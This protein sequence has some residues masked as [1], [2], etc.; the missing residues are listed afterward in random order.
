LKSQKPPTF[1]LVALNGHFR[2]CPNWPDVVC[3]FQCWFLTNQFQ[4]FSL[5]VFL[6]IKNNLPQLVNLAWCF[7]LQKFSASPSIGQFACYFLIYEIVYNYTS[8]M[9]TGT[10]YVS[11]CSAYESII[12]IIII[13]FFFL[14]A[15]GVGWRDQL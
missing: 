10:C 2:S 5:C 4:S 11:S 14:W 13:F 3:R 12:I 15:K 7:M 1:V 6:I 8:I 9:L